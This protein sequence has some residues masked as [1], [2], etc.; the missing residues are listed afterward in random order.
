MN[1]RLVTLWFAIASAAP[2]AR[3]LAQQDLRPGPEPPP[4]PAAWKPLIGDYGPTADSIPLVV[5]ERGGALFVTKKGSEPEALAQTSPGTYAAHGAPPSPVLRARGATGP[6]IAVGDVSLSHRDYV[7]ASG[8]FVVH[9][10]RPVD[11][12]RRDA[13]RAT[14]PAEAGPF[15]KP[16]LVD[17]TQ[18]DPVIHLDVRYA[19]TN[20]FLRTP[21]YTEARA[22]LQRPA[23]DALMR[24]LAKLKP[25]GYGLL[26][27]DAYRPW[28]VTKIFWDATPPEGKIFVADPAQG[29]RHNRGCA[30]DLT[31]YDLRTGKPIEMPGTYDE[32]SPRSFPDYPGGTSLERWHRDLLRAAME[33]EGY[34]VYEAEWWHFDYKDWKEYP[35]LNIP[36]EQMT[37]VNARGS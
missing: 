34:T 21:V 18:L 17:I 1:R 22:F 32:M 31:L 35:I 2:A 7:A 15:R 33:S 29:S 5:F 9:P 11:E 3:A 24:V 25:L 36:F 20:N 8:S 19:T 14:P 16:E 4:A 6:T 30:V 12:L 23:A 10:P 13:L 28:Y 27:H 37:G 26:I